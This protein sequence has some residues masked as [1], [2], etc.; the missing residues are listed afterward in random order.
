VPMRLISG[1]IVD[2]RTGRVRAEE[3]EISDGRIAAIRD[4]VGKPKTF[5]LPGFIDAHVHIES[6]MLVP[7][8]FARLAVAHGTVA[9]VS[10][11]HEIANVLGIAGVRYMVGDARQAPLKVCFGA[12]ACVPAT[13]FETAGATVTVEEI[14]E[15]LELGECYYLSEV[16]NYPGVLGGDAEMLAKLA[17]ARRL[18]KPID[19]HAP[20]MR[21]AA[22]ER[23]FGAMTGI[24]TDHECTA[25]DEALH[26]IACGAKILIR[27]GSAA[28]NYPALWT[29]LKTHPESVMFCSD[30][31]HPDDL[32]AGHI[33]ELATRALRD[34]APLANVLRAACVNPV[35]HY[36]LPVGLLRVGDPADFI[37]VDS[38]KDFTGRHVLRTFINGEV[39]AERGVALFPVTQAGEANV[40]RADRVTAADFALRAGSER[41]RVI[42]TDDGQLI[43]R[44]EEAPATMRDGCAV[45][46]AARD[47]LKL[48]VVNRYGTQERPATA[49]IRGFGIKD[50]A[51]ASSVA[52]DSHNIVAVGTDDAL[53]ARAVNMVIDNRGGLAA[54]NAGGR[55]LSLP[56]P[57]GGLMST[58]PGP[59]VAARYGALQAM[60]TAELGSS[61]KAPFM[62]LSFMALLV[63]PSLKLS[64]RGLF[65]GTRFEFTSV[66]V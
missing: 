15:L 59:E 42:A 29:L 18:G 46:D 7:S 62:T 1:Q 23:Y 35:E 25:L 52:H 41:V 20:G 5:L 49:F 64:D 2:C 30:D 40:F 61:L 65:D 8:T 32:V 66:F 22:C 19:G 51:I 24:T 63:I 57:V 43:T 56:L 16:M 47:I 4:A 17:A 11:P 58:L 33:N 10:D 54:V 14:T 38:L 31:K 55:E 9:T 53:L 27:E 36:G 37:E 45:A 50:G 34:G 60:A 26:K 44:S 6:S 39:V 48:A 12:P 21:G 28:K 3:V 13:H